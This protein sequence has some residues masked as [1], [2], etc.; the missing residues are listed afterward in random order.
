MSKK[1]QTNRLPKASNILIKQTIITDMPNMGQISISECLKALDNTNIPHHFYYKTIDDKNNKEGY[2]VDDLSIAINSNNRYGSIYFRMGNEGNW[3][4][5]YQ[6]VNDNG[7][8][9]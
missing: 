2:Y 5:Q 3:T 6:L 9:I 4:K 8:P 7:T 1:T